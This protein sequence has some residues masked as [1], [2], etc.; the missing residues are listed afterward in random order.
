[1]LHK[2]APPLKR[3]AVL[4]LAVVAVIILMTSYLLALLILGLISLFSRKQENILWRHMCSW[5][6]EDEPA[7]LVSLPSTH[8]KM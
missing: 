8:Q 5:E 6:Q 3:I 7:Y 4:S 1:M 2:I